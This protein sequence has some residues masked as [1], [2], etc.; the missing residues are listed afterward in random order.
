[1]PIAQ[2]D[3]KFFKSAAT[4]SDGGA[5]SATEITDNT[6]NNLFDD[7]SGDEAQAGDVEYRKIFIKNNHGSLTWIAV[8]A[9]IESL[10]SSTDDEIAIS[11]STNLTGSNA[12][13]DGQSYVAPTAKTHGDVLVV[14][15]LT[16]GGY[17]DIWIRR[18]VSAGAAAFTNDTA[19]LKAEGETAA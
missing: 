12:T 4:D 18:T 16:A 5:I 19:V 8:K 11:L 3:I 14:G 6:L 9:W 15:N 2:S 10:T 1:M 7:V 17:K 13:G